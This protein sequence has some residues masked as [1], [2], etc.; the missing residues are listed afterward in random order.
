MEPDYDVNPV[1]ALKY[2]GPPLQITKYTV[3]DNIFS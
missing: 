1:P 3:K 2:D